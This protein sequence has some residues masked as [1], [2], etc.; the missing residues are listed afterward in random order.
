MKKKYILITGGTGFIGSCI[1]KKL[2]LQGYNLIVLDNNFRGNF[3]RIKNLK[4][5]IVFVKCDIRNL[6]KV[7]QIF[8]KFNIYSVIHLAYINGTKN[9][10]KIPFD[11]IEIAVKGTLNILESC[12][13]YKVKECFL[14]SSSEVYADPKIIPTPEEVELKIPKLTNPRYSYGG[15]KIMIELLGYYYCKK[16]FKKMIIFRPHNVYSHD[17]GNDHVIPELIRKIKRFKKSIKA[18]KKIYIQ[19]TGKETRAFT[20]IDDF[21]DGFDI[22]FKKGKHLNVY[23]IGNNKQTSIKNLV[24]ILCKKLD[25]NGKIGFENKPSGSPNKRCPDI[26]KIKKLGFIPKVDIRKGIDK[27]ISSN[28]K[29]I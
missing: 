8:R 27:I 9:F 26:S 6:N 10:Y 23:N 11:I 1:V 28:E 29:N 19:G 14:A 17:M 4:S 16:F 18:N 5:K 20:Y 22:I 7:S 13:K 2:F 24:K 21:I 3:K 12:K 25:V 15:G